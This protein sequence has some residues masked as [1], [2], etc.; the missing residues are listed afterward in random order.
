MPRDRTIDRTEA[1]T[2]GGESRAPAAPLAPLAL[3]I[4]IKVCADCH[5]FLKGASLLLG[6]PIRVQAP[7]RHHTCCTWL[8]SFGGS[9]C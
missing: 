6:R 7:A 3:T 1:A 8:C 9:S 4:N 2:P 5:E